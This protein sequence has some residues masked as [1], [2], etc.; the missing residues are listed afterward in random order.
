MAVPTTGAISLGKIRQELETSNY[1]AGVYN[2]AAT[3]LDTAENGGYYTLNPCSP[4]LP[5]AANPAKMSEWRGYD[6]DAPCGVSSGSY[7]DYDGALGNGGYLAHGN[8]NLTREPGNLLQANLYDKWTLSMWVRPGLMSNDGTHPEYGREYPIWEWHDRVNDYHVTVYLLDY[9]A[10]SNTNQLALRI[11]STSTN[12]RVW[13][14]YL[15]DATNIGVTGVGGG[16]WSSNNLGSTNSNNFINLGFVYDITQTA[17]IDRFKV[18][19]NGLPLTTTIYNSVGTGG[20]ANILFNDTKLSVGYS[21]YFR[22]NSTGRLW[23][24]YIDWISYAN[25][26]GASAANMTTIWNSGSPLDHGSLTPI[27]SNFIQWKLN[28]GTDPEPNEAGANLDLTYQVISG[29]PPQ[30]DTTVSA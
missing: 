4:S 26:Y 7:Y 15:S 14:V 10:T 25:Q 24:G 17:P 23:F 20:P 22:N 11:G 5:L 1:A 21:D 12:Y 30:Y 29:G 3:N 27:S 8:T 9:I 18:Y 13:G 19:W 28:D 16:S 6:H 2:A